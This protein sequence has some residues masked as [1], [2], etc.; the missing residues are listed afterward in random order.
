[1]RKVVEIMFV[2]ALWNALGCSNA[3]P[4]R[5][6]TCVADKD[7]SLQCGS[8]YHAYRCTGSA[9][10]DDD[11]KYVEGVPQGSVCADHGERD[12]SGAQGYCCTTRTTSCAYNAVAICDEGS[13]GF[14]CRGSNRP[15]ALNA[16][17]SCG[18]GVEQADL[19]NFCCAG[20]PPEPGCLQTDS[21][22]CSS[23]LMGFTCRGDNLPRGEQLGANKS[24]SDYFRLL[25]SAPMAA[26]NPDYKNYCCY[27]P[28][29]LPAGGS[30]VQNTRVPGCDSGRFGFSCYGPDKPQDN[31]APMR[32][33]EP[34][35]SGLS[36]E[37]YPATLY[38]CD[39][40]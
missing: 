14:Q 34:G 12:A 15:D 13:Y 2:Y 16:A 30:C 40:Q 39:F 5:D 20:N 28:A 31:Y 4:A 10:P 37:G 26:A 35:K 18:N 7:D 25:C 24:R 1:M 32:C 17:L 27:T 38:C 3:L 11:P 33:S 8:D 6:G 29:P 21:V 9:R 19:V 22:A 36:A 23:R